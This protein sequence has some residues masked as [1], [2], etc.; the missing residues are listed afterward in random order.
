M[1]KLNHPG[2][3]GFSQ[4]KGLGKVMDFPHTGNSK[5]KGPK[6][7]VCTFVW[8]QL[9]PYSRKV[10]QVRGVRI[11]NTVAVRAKKMGFVLSA[12][13]SRRWVHHQVYIWVKKTSPTLGNRKRLRN[14]KRGAWGAN[15]KAS[16]TPRGMSVSLNFVPLG[17]FCASLVLALP[18]NVV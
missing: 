5:W 8:L 2:P 3:V 12:A 11:T 15:F 14:D 7:T 4:L 18:H 10:E 17:I 9:M 13:E 1:S 6:V 16:L